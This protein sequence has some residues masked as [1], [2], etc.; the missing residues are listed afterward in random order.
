M[1]WVF[2]LPV[3]ALLWLLFRTAERNRNL[4]AVTNLRIIDEEGLFG[5]SSKESPLDKINN[6]SYSA[7]AAGRIFGYGTVEIQTAAETGATVYHMV[8]NPRRLKDTIT[9]MQE[10]YKT[11][12]SRRQARETAETFQAAGKTGHAIGSELEKLAELRAKGVLT[13]EEFQTA[14]RKLLNG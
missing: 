14:K 13:E 8:E 3:L 11:L 1:P 10:E 7:S 6:V 12:L 4:W 5:V 9:R 2:I